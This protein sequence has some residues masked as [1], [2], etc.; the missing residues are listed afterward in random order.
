[1][2]KSRIKARLWQVERR[3][4][5]IVSNQMEVLACRIGDAERLLHESVRLVPVPVGLPVVVVL[6]AAAARVGC[7]AS[8]SPAG[9]KGVPPL[10]F[11]LPVRQE[12][13]GHSARAP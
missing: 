10:A 6:V 1:M 12:A 2:S 7:F 3:P 13:P 5:G 9:A 8:T 11:H 4:S